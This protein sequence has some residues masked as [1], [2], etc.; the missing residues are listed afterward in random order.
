MSVPVYLNKTEKLTTTFYGWPSDTNVSA[1]EDPSSVEVRIFNTDTVPDTL[2]SAETPTRIDV[3][4]YLYE[5]T[6]ASTGNFNVQFYAVFADSSTDVSNNFFIVYEAI[7][8]P[9][10]ATLQTDQIIQLT[11]VLD[12]LYL[13]PAEIEVIFPDANKVQITEY[14]YQFSLEVQSIE[15]LKD[16][17][18]PSYV[19]LEYIHAATACS[20]SKIYDD[21]SAGNDFSFRLGD[22]QVD[23]RPAFK[24]ALNRGNAGT[25][26]ELAFVLRKELIANQ[27]GI[28]TIRKGR[29]GGDSPHIIPQRKL[30]YYEKTLGYTEA[31]RTDFEPDMDN[32]RLN[33]F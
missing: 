12:P 32:P 1:P 33:T 8:A 7:T 14:I 31:L 28:T 6:P 25:W 20:L 16:G 26:C 23:S 29:G 3:G 9:S 2:V 10:G 4:R 24:T 30:R 17:Q 22:L 13:D 18:L 15:K 27:V 21:V 11:G 19:G 5:W